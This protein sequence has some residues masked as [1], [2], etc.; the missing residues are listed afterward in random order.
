VIERT[1]AL[2]VATSELKAGADERVR[3]EETLRGLEN[4]VRSEAE[5]AAERTSV[6]AEIS[7]VLVEDFMDHRPMLER[8]AQIAASATGAACVIQLIAEDG[9]DAGLLPAAVDHA[10]YAIRSELARVFSAP[11]TMADFPWHDLDRVFL[12]T[13][14]LMDSLSVPML[15][16]TAVIGV[17]SLGRFG[18]DAP[19]FTDSDRRLYDDLAARV[20]L[21]V[22]NARLYENARTAIELRD[23]F[24]TIAAHELKTP[25]DHSGLLATPIASTEERSPSG[26]C[27]STPVG[28]HDR[29]SHEAPCAAGGANSRCLAARRVA[30]AAQPG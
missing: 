12:D 21:A 29:R 23:D 14:P 8:V 4:T 22:E 6:L 7:H 25:D 24:L 11:R 19:Q 20:A 27:S 5:M 2:D 30:F 26:S 16:R 15:A 9:D 10:D 18:S 13:Y 17:L 28:A 1:A 3:T